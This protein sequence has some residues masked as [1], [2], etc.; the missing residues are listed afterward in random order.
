M[1]NVVKRVQTYHHTTSC[2][3]KNGACRFNA[4]WAPSNETRID[5]SEGK[6]DDTIVNQCKNLIEKVL[7]YNVTISDLTDVKLSEIL[8]ECG[9][10]AEKYENALACV[11]RKVSALYKPK[12]CEVNIGPYHTVILKLLKSKMNLQFVP[13]VYRM[14]IYLTPYLC[15]PEHEMSKLMK[16]ASKKA[17]GKVIKGKMYSIGNTFLTNCK[18][19]TYEA[20]K[21][22]LSLPMRHSNIDVL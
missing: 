15:K 18:V 12:P 9:V 14:L 2:R 5:C 20:I 17:Y 22:V 8:E 7:S 3:K 10:T 1:S 21:R 6:I 16:K 11:E 13:G 4:P 19:S